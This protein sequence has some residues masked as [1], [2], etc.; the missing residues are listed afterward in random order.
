VGGSAGQ[1]SGFDLDAIVLSYTDISDTSQ[2]GTLVP[3]AVFNFGGGTVFTPGTQRLPVDPKLYGTDALGTH[4][5][6]AVATLGSFDG[7]STT[8]VPPAFGFVSM[9]DGGVLSFN[10]TSAV[11]S[12]NLH[13]YIGEVGDNGEVADGTITVSQT[14]VPEPGTLTLL[15][16]GLLG[17]IRTG[18]KHRRTV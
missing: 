3:L 16:I 17:A 12:T 9:G 7:E 15:G 6:N 18:R 2:L 10:L 11:D 14:T 8:A 4:V 1:F 5:D 13:L